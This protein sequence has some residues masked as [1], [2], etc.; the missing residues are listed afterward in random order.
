[1][2]DVLRS[3]SDWASRSGYLVTWADRG[4]LDLAYKE[5]WTRRDSGELDPEFYGRWL[6]PVTAYRPALGPAAS[7]I[8]IIAVPR[9]AH[10]VRFETRSGLIETIVPPVFIQDKS[11]PKR[12]LDELTGL[13]GDGARLEPMGGKQGLHKSVAARAGLVRYGRTNITFTSGFGSYLQIVPFVTDVEIPHDARAP[14]APQA[15]DECTDCRLCEHA[16]PTGAI[17]ADRFLLRAHRC[18]VYFNEDIYEWPDWL[19]ATSHHCLVGCMKCQEAC[20]ANAGKL[21]LETVPEVFTFQETTAI[22]ND[23]S[24]SDDLQSSARHGPVW[25][26]IRDKLTSIKLPWL[27][28][29]I[30]RNMRALEKA[31]G[32]QWS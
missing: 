23:F 17:G 18:L 8:L 11:V 31:R 20:P 6:E 28:Y 12:I 26:S 10:I 3:V 25:D 22:L 2:V 21:R 19:P 16:C 30:G 27:E 24:R 4:L 5:V 13:V 29:M 1:L 9:P 14:K 32:C 15:L 7:S